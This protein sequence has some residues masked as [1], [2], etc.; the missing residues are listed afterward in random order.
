ML[1]SFVYLFNCL[2][3]FLF[4]V[5]GEEMRERG[6]RRRKS[7]GNKI[8]VPHATNLYKKGGSDK[9]STSCGYVNLDY[10]GI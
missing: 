1:L 6:R 10:T 7:L 5:D 3:N 8:K 9:H 4:K 2:L